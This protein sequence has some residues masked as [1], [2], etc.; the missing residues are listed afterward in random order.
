MSFVAPPCEPSWALPAALAALG[1]LFLMLFLIGL[2][3][4][5]GIRCGRDDRDPH[6]DAYGDQPQVPS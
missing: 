2:A 5:S 6:D 1:L 4:Q 3:A